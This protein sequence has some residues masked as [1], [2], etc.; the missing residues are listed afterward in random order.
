MDHGLAA[1][2]AQPPFDPADAPEAATVA[3]G[4]HE[5]TLAFRD[6]SSETLASET[7]RL[8]CRCAWCTRARIEGRFPERFE[9]IAVTDVALIGGYAAHVTFSDGHD[10]G[11]YPWTYLRRLAAG[12]VTPAEPARAA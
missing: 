3:R 10:R 6:G 9:A 1:L 7:L 11:I 5:L 4:G 12:D 8:N 2:V